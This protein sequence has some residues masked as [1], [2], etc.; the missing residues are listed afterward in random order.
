MRGPLFQPTYSVV[1]A[2]QLTARELE[3][4]SALFSENYGTWGEGAGDRAGRKIRLSAKLFGM[5]YS[6]KT[7][8]FVARMFDGERLVGQVFYL[9]RPCP[10]KRNKR[11]TFILQLVLDKSARG[12]RLGLSLLQSIFGLS[13][14][15]AWGLFTSNP[16]T[17]RA[18][19][20]ATFRH[21]DVKRVRR[22]L[23]RIRPAL[24]DVFS[25]GG[26]WL[27]SFRNGAVDTHFP[28]DHSQIAMKIKKAYPQGGFPF[29]DNLGVSEEWLAVIFR[30]QSVD[31]N[32][33]N[34]TRLTTTSR[35]VLEGAFSRMDLARHGWNTHAEEEVDFL[36]EC[37]YI[38]SG[39]SVLD[40]GCGTGRHSIALAT[41]GCRVHGVDF[42]SALIESARLEAAK[43][44]FAS[45]SASFTVADAQ[46]ATFATKFD[47]VICLYDVIGASQDQRTNLNIVSTIW[48]ALKPG[49]IA[50]VSVMNSRLVDAACRKASNRIVG[51]ESSE[52]FTKL[53]KMSP[54]N[55]MQ[56][57]GEVFKGRFLLFNPR[58]ET[59]YHKEQFS[60]DGTLPVEYVIA[61]RRFSAESIV[62]LF[63]K[64]EV[65]SIS[66]VRAG[67]FGEP[68]AATDKH[69]KEVLGIFRKPKRWWN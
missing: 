21:V 13:D 5:M 59:V 64:F 17:I 1:P 11:L 49:G 57:T 60:G 7:D 27:D 45:G 4:C 9:R 25:D 35:D 52:L 15:E 3:Q 28:A 12:H 42:S 62:E 14:D 61:E 20:D 34:F 36:I 6:A 54:S 63:D 29:T 58:T 37:K 32:A 46:N 43:H 50:I 68:L 31:F 69:A 2:S 30:N 18:L 67:H 33:E 38:V 26:A 47:A 19:E 48:N 8:C 24:S 23:G 40:V 53:A 66:Y 56:S 22:S 41:A 51:D 44:V 65:V 10:W 39:S 55:T 16:L